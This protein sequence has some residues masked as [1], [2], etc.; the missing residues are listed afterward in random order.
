MPYDVGSNWGYFKFG[1][2]V[3]CM[4]DLVSLNTFKSVLKIISM[5]S[6]FFTQMRIALIKEPY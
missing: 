3:C 5:H 2:C 1:V 6:F 4:R